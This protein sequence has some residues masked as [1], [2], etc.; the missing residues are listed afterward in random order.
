MGLFLQLLARGLI[1]GSL[2]ALLGVSWGIIY[3]T[4]RTFHF[5]HG[6]VYTLASYLI[7]VPVGLSLPLIPSLLVGLIAA[8][9]AGCAIEY[10]AYLPM[11]EKNASQLSVFLTAMGIMIAGQSLILLIFGPDSRPLEGFPERII[12]L[13]PITL[14]SI[15]LFTVFLAWIVMAIL[16]LFLAR[17]KAGMMIR[18]VSSNPEKATFIGIDSKKIFL[19]VFGIGS[20]LVGIASFLATLDRPANPNIGLHALLISFITVFLGGVGNLKGAMIGGLILGIAESLVIMV[21]PTEYKM[22][23]TFFILFLVILIKPE[24]LMGKKSV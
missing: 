20:L 22:V 17:T 8:T 14:T 15:D 23:V 7:L 13:G 24:G 10:F 2:Y 5:A 21:L 11:R 9:A 19:L 4:T 3:N 6:F 12:S 1:T 16:F 18:A